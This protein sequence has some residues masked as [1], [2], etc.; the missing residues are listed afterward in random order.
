[1]TVRRFAVHI[2]IVAVIMALTSL[3]IWLNWGPVVHSAA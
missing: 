1:M 3:A 2:L